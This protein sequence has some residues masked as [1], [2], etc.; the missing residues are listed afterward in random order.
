MLQPGEHCPP[1]HCLFAAVVSGVL[2]WLYYDYRNDPST[3]LETEKE[4]VK[5]LLGYAIFSTIITVSSSL[6]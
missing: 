1:S 6:Q 3:E 5:F 2:W 4:N